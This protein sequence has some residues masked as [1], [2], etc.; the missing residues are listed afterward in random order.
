MCCCLCSLEL[1]YLKIGVLASRVVRRVIYCHLFALVS[2]LLWPDL[3]VFVA[4]AALLLFLVTLGL[5][6]VRWEVTEAFLVGL[7]VE[8]Y[9]VLMAISIVVRRPACVLGG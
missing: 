2:H 6:Y 9:S 7:S 1:Y 4:F 8:S 5:F 3:F